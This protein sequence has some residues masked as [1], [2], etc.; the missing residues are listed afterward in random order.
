[1]FVV[2]VSDVEME[3][4]FVILYPSFVAVV[5]EMRKLRFSVWFV[6]IKRG[7][8]NS[9]FIFCLH[10]LVNKVT[11]IDAWKLTGVVDGAFSPWGEWSECGEGKCGDDFQTRLRACSSPEPRNG[12]RE[13][14]GV[15]Q[16]CRYC[17]KE[18]GVFDFRGGWWWYV[19]AYK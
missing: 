18:A 2:G 16:E 7:N 15:S 1:M 3:R 17:P 14:V 10:C 11:D 13:C 5:L 9:V 19:Q 8:A 12:G 6:A 4:A